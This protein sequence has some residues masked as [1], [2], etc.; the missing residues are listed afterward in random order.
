VTAATFPAAFPAGCIACHDVSAPSVKPGPVCQTCHVA[1]S[2][3]T[4][5][6][7]TSCH[8]IPPDSGAPAGAAYPNIEGAH[9]EHIALTSA[10]TPISCDTCHDGLGSGTLAHYVR[11]GA[12]RV[13]PGDVAFPAGFLYTG[14]AGTAVTFDN[15]LAALTCSNV[16]CHGAL[17]T[18]NWR[19]GTTACTSCHNSATVAP[20]FYTDYTQAFITH[21]Q[22]INRNI[23]CTTCHTTLPAAT[24]FGTLSDKAIASRAAAATINPAFLYPSPPPASL[25]ISNCTTGCH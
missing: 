1:A 3:L 7:C 2:P 16:S 13:E 6:N 15:A 9:A 4:S 21:T 5:L 23:A 10:G 24:H 18:P 14:I 12:A 25:L 11:A 17:A 20:V 19:T 22:H 8:A